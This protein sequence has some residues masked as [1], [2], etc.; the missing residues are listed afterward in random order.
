[1]RRSLTALKR[2]SPGDIITPELVAFVRPGGGVSPGEEAHF[3]GRRSIAII[4]AGEQ[5]K[6]ENLEN[7]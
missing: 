2:I 3:Y 1:M 4:E 5:I 6:L 7:L